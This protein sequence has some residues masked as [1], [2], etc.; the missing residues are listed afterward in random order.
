MNKDKETNLL[1]LNTLQYSH[2]KNTILIYTFYTLHFI[3]INL[4]YELSD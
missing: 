4:V 1:F 3:V 2:D